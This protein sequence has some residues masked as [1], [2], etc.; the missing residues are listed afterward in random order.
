MIGEHARSMGAG[1]NLVWRFGAKRFQNGFR[2]ANKQFIAPV[3]VPGANAKERARVVAYAR[4]LQRLHTARRDAVLE[5]DRR[6]MSGQTVPDVRPASWIWAT[7]GS[8]GHYRKKAPLG[9]EKRERTSWAKAERDRILQEHY[10]L[11]P[12]RVGAVLEVVER[13]GELGLLVDGVAVIDGVF[14]DDAETAFIAAQWRHKVGETTVTPTFGAKRLIELLLDLRRTDNL[15]LRQQVVELDAR[16]G[17]IDADI[18]GAET[19]MNEFLYDLYALTP[20]EHKLV[21]EDA[22]RVRANA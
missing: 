22:R 7:V 5:I 3:P 17:K 11:I 9:L 2:S 4:E 16:I 15:A 21:E 8:P 13:P 10:R 18:C 19:S 12:I 1:P 14:V 20:E 6:L